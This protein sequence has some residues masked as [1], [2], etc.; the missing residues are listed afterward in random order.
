[1]ESKWIQ[2]ELRALRDIAVA[3]QK[4]VNDRFA[5][6]NELR[7]QVLQ[8][9]GVFVRHEAL[10]SVSDRLARLEQTYINRSE[11]DV[12]TARI[13][14]LER[15]GITRPEFESH[16]RRL[17]KLEALGPLVALIA[18][19]IGGGIVYAITRWAG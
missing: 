19:V 2:S 11:Y 13:V 16:G 14:T 18:T 6:V 1:M 10:A 7:E 17:G 12:L 9:R 3:E 5:Q 15:Q 8:E 4:R